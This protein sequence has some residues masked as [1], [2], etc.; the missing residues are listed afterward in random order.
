[1]KIRHDATVTPT[2]CI[3]K[4]IDTGELIIYINP[5]WFDALTEEMQI[6]ILLHELLHVRTRL[7]RQQ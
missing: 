1:M 4:Q 5:E 2:A 7:R 3:A 6:E